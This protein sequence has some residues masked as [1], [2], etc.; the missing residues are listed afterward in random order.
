MV[1]RGFSHLIRDSWKLIALVTALI[2]VGSVARR[3]QVQRA[4][5]YA[6]SG[7]ILREEAS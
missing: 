7:E 3:H 5:V 4:P 2:M 6:E 1:I